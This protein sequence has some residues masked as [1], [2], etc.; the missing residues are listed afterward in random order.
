MNYL[1]N[2]YIFNTDA[3]CCGYDNKILQKAP[4]AWS[5]RLF[6]HWNASLRWFYR[7]TLP[8]N[9]TLSQCRSIFHLDKTRK[10]W[11]Y[12]G[13][14]TQKRC[15]SRK[16]FLKKVPIPSI[17]EP[18]SKAC[19]GLP[20]KWRLCWWFWWLWIARFS[21]GLL[22]WPLRKPL[23]ENNNRKNTLEIKKSD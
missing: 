18:R 20:W 12:L 23:F 5:Q 16:K 21:Y 15:F 7:T 8:R 1:I 19:P 2:G 22:F 13:D 10:S 3:L 11:W 4:V 9:I 6:S 17:S 14:P